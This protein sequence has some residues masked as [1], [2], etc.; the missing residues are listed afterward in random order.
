MQFLQWPYRKRPDAPHPMR[1]ICILKRHRHL[2]SCISILS[3]ITT[4]HFS[5]VCECVHMCPL[6]DLVSIHIVPMC[7]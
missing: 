3:H 4:D 7:H 2:F 6:P 1:A 5:N